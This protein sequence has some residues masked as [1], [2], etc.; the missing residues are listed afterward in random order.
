LA[1]IDKLLR[2][3]AGYP[4]PKDISYEE[5]AKLLLSVKCRERKAT[6]TRHRQFTYPGFPEVITLMQ[7]EDV[8]EY[9]I[10]QV[11]ELLKFIGIIEED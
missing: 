4:I 3:I 7:N 6:G 2:R 10:K 8:K 5:M 11:R 1:K 9:K